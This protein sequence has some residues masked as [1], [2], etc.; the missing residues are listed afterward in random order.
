V[1]EPYGRVYLITNTVNG[2]VYVGQTRRTL[3]HRWGQHKS[4]ALAGRSSLLLRA[5]RKYGPGSFEMTELEQCPTKDSLNG[6][7]AKW[8]ST[9][10]SNI[11]DTGYN[12]TSGGESSYDFTP[13]VLQAMSVSAKKRY[14]DPAARRATSEALSRLWAEPGARQKMSEAQKRRLEDPAA[15]AR[16][17]AAKKKGYVESPE[18]QVALAEASRSYNGSPEGRKAQ[19]DA[20]K[21]AIRSNPNLRKVRS[22]NAKRWFAQ[23]PE[24]RMRFSRAGVAGRAHNQDSS[25]EQPPQKEGSPA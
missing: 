5:I 2:K 7:E 19:S 4:A 9:C 22:D 18:L 24:A 8:V 13:E 12:C 23:H 16:M 17:S 14:E 1:S 6:A 25:R 15:R 10:K 20:Q 11:R 21:S 3:K